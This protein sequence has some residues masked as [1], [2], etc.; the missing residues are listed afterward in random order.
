MGENPLNGNGV[1]AA[2]FIGAWLR[3]SLNL[4]GNT[5]MLLVNKK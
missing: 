2:L 4:C 5:E 3:N 1:A